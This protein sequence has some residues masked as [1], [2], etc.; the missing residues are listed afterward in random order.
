MSKTSDSAR[1]S[2]VQSHN[3][4]RRLDHL[5]NI[6]EGIGF[7][8]IPDILMDALL[9]NRIPV[10]KFKL[11]ACMLRHSAKFKIKRSYLSARFSDKTLQKYLPEIERDGFVRREKINLASGGFEVI[12]HTNRVEYWKLDSDPS[13]RK[14]SLGKPSQRKHLKETKSKETKKNKTNMDGCKSKP[15]AKAP[16][17][18]QPPSQKIDAIDLAKRFES[19]FTSKSFINFKENNDWFLSKVNKLGPRI[20][21]DFVK[22]VEDTHD[23]GRYPFSIRNREILFDQWRES[24]GHW[25]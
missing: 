8:A 20:V 25:E 7:T 3:A 21:L 5:S 15:L 19:H 10:A 12:Y 24:Q 22:W 1:Q 18:K 6:Q 11:I 14:P 9:N 17:K 16:E 13:Q 23:R 4:F 2:Q